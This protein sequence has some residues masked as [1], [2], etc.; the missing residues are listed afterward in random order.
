MREALRAVQTQQGAILEADVPVSFGNEAEARSA[1]SAGV[2]LVDRSHWGR[3]L[4]SDADRLNFLHNQST[5]T[6]KQRQ[7]GE[8]CDT[9]FQTSTART[10]DLTT[11][12]ILEDSVLLLVSP[13]MAD[14]LIS[15]L[16]RYIFF[17]DKVKLQP[18]T[19]DTFCFSA[20]G[21][22]SSALIESLGASAIVGQP[23]GT[24][25]TGTI[26]D[27]PIH[28]AVGSGLVTEGYTIWGQ[29]ALAAD[30]WQFL[31]D[32]GAVPLGDRLWEQ[33][34]IEQG[35]PS[36]GHELTEDYNP[37]EA[38]LWQTI[39]FNKGCYIG[40]ETIA[41]LDT[42]KGVKLQL[43]GVRL[44]SAVDLGT[45]VMLGDEKVGTLTSLAAT[46]AGFV[47]LAYVRTKAG[48]EGLT[49]QIADQTTTLLD[50]PYLT[51]DRVDQPTNT[52]R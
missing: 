20:I 7:P 36:P 30:L 39:S 46:D 19:D 41:R 27:Q 18:V 13:G 8:G 49:V 14:R 40:Q 44:S 26:V 38:G 5:Q 4:V 24:H 52:P 6:F 51:R 33:L 16:D 11:A 10:I 12:Y 15:F 28:I 47:G 32:R 43:W 45:P 50:L 23:Y 29:M 42:Y 25:T 17:A 3:I 9:V 35:R 48:G 37:L 34:R 31:S 21:P 2:A 1:M 22:G